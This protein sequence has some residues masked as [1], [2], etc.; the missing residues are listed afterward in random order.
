MVRGIS[1]HQCSARA[2]ICSPARHQPTMPIIG[3]GVLLFCGRHALLQSTGVN[4]RFVT[5]H[6]PQACSNWPYSPLS[7]SMYISL[8]APPCHPQHAFTGL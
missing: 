5:P 2:S 7:L 1:P 3:S 6:S 8:N 4:Q